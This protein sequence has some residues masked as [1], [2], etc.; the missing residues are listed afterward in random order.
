M[1]PE[2]GPTAGQFDNSAVIEETLA[3]KH[4]LALLLDFNNAAEESL[5][6]G[7]MA[8]S[9]AQVL[10][11][12]T[13]LAQR[14]KPQA[15]QDL[16][17]LKAF[18]AEL[19]G[20]DQLQAWDI[21]YYSEKLKMAKYAISDELLRPYFPEPTVVAGL[22]SVLQ[23]VFGVVVSQRQGVDVWHPDVKFYRYPRWPMVS[24]AAVFTWIY[25]PS[26]PKNAVAPGWTSARAGS[27]F[28]LMEPAA[29]SGLSH[30]Q[31]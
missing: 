17:E 10:D 19:T 8:D 12:L 29:A 9:P 11:F 28:E 1:L 15:Q 16:A 13:D 31:L 22:F 26:E 27:G 23:K 2:Q 21:G 24:C 4:E 14:A 5:A 25:I 6:T 30:L 18:A 7:K 3:L 20:T